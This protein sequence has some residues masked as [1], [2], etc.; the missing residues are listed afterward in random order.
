MFVLSLKKCVFVGNRGEI[1]DALNNN[2]NNNN[3]NNEI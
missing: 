1:Y 3:N 2:N